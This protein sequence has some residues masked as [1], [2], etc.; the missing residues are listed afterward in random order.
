MSHGAFMEI[1][2][3]LCVRNIGHECF[4]WSLIAFSLLTDK[5]GLWIIGSYAVSLRWITYPQYVYQL[6]DR[7]PCKKS[8]R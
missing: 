4:I 7:L 5:S 6:K 8:D 1:I 3:Y 2:M